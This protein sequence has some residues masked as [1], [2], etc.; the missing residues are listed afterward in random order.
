MACTCENERVCVSFSRETSL[1][2]ERKRCPGDVETRWSSQES[3]L[4]L[5]ERHQSIARLVF[6][7]VTLLYE[8]GIPFEASLK[9]EARVNWIASLGSH[10]TIFAKV[11]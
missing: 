11:S 3:S 6:N 10:V 1:R 7:I 8:D 5:P 2:A 9:R 4:H